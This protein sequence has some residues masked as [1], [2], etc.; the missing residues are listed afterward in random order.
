[1]NMEILISVNKAANVLGVHPNTVR[2]M[3]KQ[4][5]LPAKK[6][7]RQW[8]IH[9]DRFEKWVEKAYK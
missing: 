9:R 3:A 6:F 4:G 2:S 5:I 7:G 8:R 1:M